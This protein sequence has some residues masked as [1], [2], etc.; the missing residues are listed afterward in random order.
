MALFIGTCSWNYDSWVGL[1][2]SRASPT[3]AGYL[4]EYS[5]RYRT[6]EIDSWFYRMPGPG[7][8]REYA[9]LTDPGFVFTCKAP[10]DLTLPLLPGGDGSPNPAFLSPGLYG[11]FMERIESLGSRA[12]VVMLEFGYMN[13]RALPGREAFLERLS[14]FLAAIPRKVPV[15]IECRN[16]S[17]LDE[18]WYAFLADRGVSAVFS[19]MRFLPGI[20]LL[21][22]RSGGRLADPVVI[23]LLGGDRAAIETATGGEWNRIVDPK[24]RLPEIAGMI[25]DLTGRGHQVYVNVNNHFEGSA[26]L[27]IERLRTLLPDA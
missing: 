27:T 22:A 4:R 5:A 13:R 2:Y 23:R 11:V 16:G 19:E 1:V 24:P 20:A 17:W 26:P 12:G 8:V 7:E 9:A 21:H 14:A 18:S 6:V 10:R 15:A 3:A 25:H